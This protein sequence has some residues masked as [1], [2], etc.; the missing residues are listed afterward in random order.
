M[1]YL[2][3]GEEINFDIAEK[4]TNYII[5]LPKTERECYGY[6]ENSKG[7]VFV[8]YNNKHSVHAI[9][10]HL[11]KSIQNGH[12]CY[13][14]E[15]KPIGFANIDLAK[16]SKNL[17]LKFIKVLPEFQSMGIGRELLSYI[18]SYAK[19]K[20]CK[21]QTLD[22]LSTYTDGH[23]VLEFRN[24]KRDI[25]ILKQMKIG[26]AKVIDKN[27]KFY[28]S[29]DYK[30]QRNRKPQNDYLT[31]MV[32]TNIKL[33]PTKIKSLF[34]YVHIRLTRF[35]IKSYALTPQAETFIKSQINKPK[36][37]HIYEVAAKQL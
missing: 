30:R 37:Q 8:M 10:F 9:T 1:K 19:S 35:P 24:E 3:G 25:A 22:C 36:K 32:K 13:E 34:A 7:E 26:G 5:N 31:P 33:R 4:I 11:K 12:V 18:E 29:A 2:V 21:T 17:H 28:L 15:G 23:N 20:G 14:L 6:G 27:L 16:K